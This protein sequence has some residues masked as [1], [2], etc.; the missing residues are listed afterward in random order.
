MDKVHTILVIVN[1]GYNIWG[2][3]L[4]KNRLSTN[5]EPIGTLAIDFSRTSFMEPHHLVSLAC[6]IEEYHLAGI[7]IKFN[8][9]YN[10]KFNKY[11]DDIK[12]CEYWNPGFNRNNFTRG[13]I[14]TT[15]CLWKVSEEM[16]DSYANQAQQYFE[17]N[18]FSGEK[19][20]V[21]LS[22]SLK[23]VFNNIFNHADSPVDGY[24]LT[25][26]YPQRGNGEIV[27]AVCDFGLGIPTKIN[28]YLAA[29]GYEKLKEDKALE[30]AFTLH[31]SSKSTPQNKG[32]GLPNLMSNVESLRG[33]LHVYSNHACLNH[34]CSKGSEFYVTNKSFSGTLINVNL[35]TQYLP[36]SEEIIDDAEF[37]F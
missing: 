3:F 36:Q 17:Q 7:T 22:I 8:P 27:T 25:Q 18:Y 4:Q 23:E 10:T 19:D 5:S 20:L 33:D 14:S 21:A 13:K 2:E 11:L 30:Q 24:V 34:A 9:S 6:L 29:N 1:R 12:F 35:K 32:L 26:Y 15:L 16:I 31:F 37:I 28:N